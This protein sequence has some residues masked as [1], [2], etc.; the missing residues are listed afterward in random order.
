VEGE[1][2]ARPG[3]PSERGHPALAA[4]ARRPLRLLPALGASPDASVLGPDLR[5]AA[6]AVL[7]AAGALAL[8]AR[9]A[10]LRRS[11]PCALER[12]Q[13]GPRQVL[14]LVET[15]GRRY[16]VATG[17]TV[18]ALPLEEAGERR[19]RAL[20]PSPSRGPIRCPCCSCSPR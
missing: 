17:G 16:L 8:A 18:T 11:R 2:A 5:G 12:V 6:A 3:A 14:V 19:L 13:V 9:P 4:L 1:V 15:G 10:L 20:A 7:A